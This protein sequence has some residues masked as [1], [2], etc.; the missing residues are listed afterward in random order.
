MSNINPKN[1]LPLNKDGSIKKS[2]GRPKGVPN[3]TT[4][5]IREA[6]LKTFDNI[7]GVS[8]MEQLAKDEPRAFA[9]LLAKLI[10][11]GVQAVGT[12]GEAAPLQI[13]IVL[14]KPK[15]D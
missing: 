14:E 1:N 9:Q 11:Q 12:D 5:S 3:K 15:E 8:W 2:P 6:L 7:G 13:K 10:P 4:T